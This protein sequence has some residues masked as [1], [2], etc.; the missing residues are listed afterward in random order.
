MEIGRGTDTSHPSLLLH[1]PM[2]PPQ[3][4]EEDRRPP[5]LGLRGLSRIAFQPRS[6][7]PGGLPPLGL[8]GRVPMPSFSIG[9]AGFERAAPPS[10]MP[11]R[12][13]GL[14]R[15]A[16]H[17]LAHEAGS[18]NWATSFGEGGAGSGQDGTGSR[19]NG[20]SSFVGFSM[21]NGGGGISFGGSNSRGGISFGGSNSGGAIGGST[22][23][24]R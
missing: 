18:S 1:D 2:A 13:V 17:P 4:R 12:R 16:R 24:K 6:S 15:P 11:R 8:A 5:P 22:T 19:G 7:T 3:P 20:G 10:V 23:G 9:T 14:S 21:L